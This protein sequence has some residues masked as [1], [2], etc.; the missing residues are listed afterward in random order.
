MLSGEKILITGASGLVGMEL[1]RDLVPNNEVWGL[2]RYLDPADREATVNAWAVSR[3]DV[4]AIGVKTV[5]ADLLGDLNHVPTDFTYLIHLAHTRLPLD[6]LEFAVEVNAVGAGRIMHHCRNAKAALIMSSTAVYSAQKD[7]HHLLKEG[8]PLGGQVPP[9]HNATSPTAKISLEAIAQFCAAQFDLRTVI[10]R[11]NTIYGP[12]GGLP[13]RDLFRIASGVKLGWFGDPYP[14]SPI[15]FRDMSDQLGAL[16]DAA[17][18]KGNIVNWCGD[19]VIQQRAWCE[20]AAELCG[21]SYEA[22]HLPGA[23]ANGADPA[24][25]LSITGPCKRRFKEAYGE[26][27]ASYNA[28]RESIERQLG[29]NRANKVGLMG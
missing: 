5:A 1:A 20:L 27:Y 26:I 2:S 15:H 10:M 16:M 23:P 19:E 25:R 13:T 12:S 22:D 24:K 14:H 8:D 7:V 21:K 9:F 11:A 18:S 29:I 3:G 28:N 4:D 17:H 6:R